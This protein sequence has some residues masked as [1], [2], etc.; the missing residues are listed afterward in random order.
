[1]YQQLVKISDKFR[2]CELSVKK[3]RV[4]VAN[5]LEAV[6]LDF[7][8]TLQNNL[9]CYAQNVDELVQAALETG[10]LFNGLCESLNQLKDASTV[11]LNTVATTA[12]AEFTEKKIFKLLK[13]CLNTVRSML[14]FAK[15][16]FFSIKI[17]PPMFD[18]IELEEITKIRKL[19]DWTEIYA[20]YGTSSHVWYAEYRGMKNEDPPCYDGQQPTHVRFYWLA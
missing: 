18:A 10:T 3:A 12:T 19:I 17:R 9:E 11:L 15:Q 4:I 5:N 8:P 1:M 13:N 7:L 2:K 6:N 16:Q 20:R 14:K